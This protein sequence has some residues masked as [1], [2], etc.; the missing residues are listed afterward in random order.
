MIRAIPFS[1]G[2]VLSGVAFAQQPASPAPAAASPKPA[3]AAQHDATDPRMRDTPMRC[4]PGQVDV[5]GGRTLGQLFGADWP[6]SPEASRRTPAQ[7]VKLGHVEW[8]AQGGKGTATS[9]VLVDAQGKPLRT[10]V[11]CASTQALV[12][13]VEAAAM[14][15]TY[16]AATFDGVAGTGVALVTWRVGESSRTP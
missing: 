9:A 7:A 15:G 3:A 1:L 14:Q 8:P 5:A 2:L 16:R 4:R 6:A 11:L 10:K 12:A 13:P